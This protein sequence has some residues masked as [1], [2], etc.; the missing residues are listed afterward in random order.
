MRRRDITIGSVVYHSVFPHY[1]KGVVLKSR[2]KD[3]LGYPTTERYLIKW[4]GRDN[5]IWCRVSSLR[6]TFNQKKANLIA[7]LRTKYE[8]Q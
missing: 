7:Q 5:E 1:G 2:V 4:D 6:K 3:S 8:A